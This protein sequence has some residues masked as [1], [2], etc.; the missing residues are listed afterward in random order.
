M[1]EFA[2]A[3]EWI[4]PH[5]RRPATWAYV[6][7]GLALSGATAHVLQSQI[8]AGFEKATDVSASLAEEWRC[9]HRKAS[10]LSDGKFTILISRL[11]GDSDRSQTEEVT[12]ALVGQGGVQLVPVCQSLQ[13]DAEGEYV[14]GL[15]AAIEQGQGI[16][17][18]RHADLILFGK[19]SAIDGSVRIWAVNEHGGCEN[20]LQP[21][22]LKRGVL[23]GQF[24]SGTKAKLYG[25]VLKEIA[26]ACR[27]KDDM[28]WDAFKKQMKKLT[29]LVSEFTLELPQEEQL[30]LSTSYYNGLNLLYN[31]DGDE[32]WFEDAAGF[33]DLL[34]HSKATDLVKQNAWFFIGRALL[35]KGNKTNDNDTLTKSIEVLEH[36]LTLI[37]AS[38]PE[39]RAQALTTRALA[40]VG[41]AMTGSRYR[42]SMRESA[43][44]LVLRLTG[45]QRL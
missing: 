7:I 8:S 5:L 22:V 43:L 12:A 26:A 42:I 17:K 27:H 19:V 15:I 21:V 34:L 28:N 3:T 39:F 36:A 4:L 1:L 41:R 33:T 23:P 32:A 38:D 11:Q 40:Y 14:T 35:S 6:T 25:A 37:P 2:R 13:I 44:Y 9:Q 30:E 24:E 18:E 10:K 31:H 16:L 20:S 29:A 45:V